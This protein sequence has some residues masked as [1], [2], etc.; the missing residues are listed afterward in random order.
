M[1]EDASRRL[2]GVQPIGASRDALR[3]PTTGGGRVVPSREP[4][5]ESSHESRLRV[6][7]LFFALQAQ[8]PQIAQRILL[9][10]EDHL[11]PWL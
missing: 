6:Y 4:Q 3:E 9:G 5:T 2:T 1:G 7:Q 11:I 10:Y 8:T